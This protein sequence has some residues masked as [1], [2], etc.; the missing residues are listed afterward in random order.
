MT[1]PIKSSQ[2]KLIAPKAAAFLTLSAVLLAGCA[3]QSDTATTTSTSTT[4]SSTST[5]A[6]TASSTAVSEST[7]TTT[8]SGAAT[9]ASGAASGT[10]AAAGTVTVGSKIDTE[11]ALLCQITKLS[12]IDAGFTVND[13]CSTGATNVVRSA[14]E[15]GEIDLYPEY[16]GSAIYILNEAGAKID[17]AVSRD[18]QQAYDTVKKLDAEKGIVW[19]DRAPANNTW[20]IAVPEALAEENN[21]NTMADFGRWVSGGAKVKLAAS[22]E[23]VDRPDALKAFEATYGF[24]L[25]PDQ[26]VIVPG[27]NTTQTETAAAQGTSGVNAAMA[28]G[29]DGALS[30]LKLR[31]LTDPEGAVAVYQPALTVRQKTLE[32]FPQIAD[33]MNPVFAKL[34]ES[35]LAELNGRIAVNGEDAA[36]VA[37]DWLSTQ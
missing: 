19:L 18:A 17:E 34:D 32:Q 23:F 22:Q 26:L 10:T 25:S 1:A 35:T 12:L 4:T 3:P 30:A 31:A 8:A 24:S 15:Q 9:T 6:N 16:T 11:G 28:Y 21:L 2:T 13:K 37:Q 29:T 5:T 7:T 14:L 27:G 20:A 36:K 33:V